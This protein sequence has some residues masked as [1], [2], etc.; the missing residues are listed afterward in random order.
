M[1][2]KI[3][4][5]AL[6]LTLPLAHSTAG[7]A[8]YP[9][10]TVTI[11]APFAAG[12]AADTVARIVAGK[13]GE[14]IGQTVIVENRAGAS[15]AIGS[16]H[17]AGATPDGYTLLVN[18]GPPHQTVGLFSKAV[19]Y[20]PIEDFTAIT[21]IATAPQAVVVPAASK[22]KTARDLLEAARSSPKGITYGT[23]GIGTSQHLAGLL[24]ASS[25]KAPM[26]HIAYRGGSAALADVVGG[27][28]DAGILVLSN[29]LPHVANGRLRM[30]GLV[31][32]NRSASAPDIPTLAENGITDFSVPDTWVGLLGPA[33][34]PADVV[35]K[36]SSAMQDV[37][38]EPDVRQQLTQAGYDVK[39]EGSDAFRNTLKSGFAVYQ[40]IVGE[41]G[42]KPE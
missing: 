19:Q 40:Q 42:I 16:A 31:D 6:W 23:S 28:V 24:L 30:I 18:L 1:M 20:D 8:A 29:V 10:K 25:Q 41:A 3:L 27:Q 11:V 35:Q 13:L 22:I 37:L 34:L 14:K 38:K 2:H 7:A 39:G 36:L 26:T 17:V 9:Q 32:A 33:K 4:F 5:G 12:G 15:G 21:L